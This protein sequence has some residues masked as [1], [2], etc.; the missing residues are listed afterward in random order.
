[1][2]TTCAK[3]WSRKFIRENFSNIF[4]NTKFKEH[5][6]DVL[7]NS[8]KALLPATQ[9]FVEEIIRKEKLKKEI[10]ETHKLIE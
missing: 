4:I 5:L 8:E 10:N 6:E 1:M 3:E 2:N 9:P 7:F